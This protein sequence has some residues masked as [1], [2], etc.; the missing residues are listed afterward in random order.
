MMIQHMLIHIATNVI[1]TVLDSITMIMKHRDMPGVFLA[2]G[3]D[4]ADRYL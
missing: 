3:A 1:P 2:K 4:V